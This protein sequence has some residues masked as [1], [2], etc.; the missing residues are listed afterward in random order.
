MWAD[1]VAFVA[2]LVTL[3]IGAEWTVRGAARLARALG[4]S[5]LLVGLTIVALGTSAPELVVGGLASAQD[6]GDLAFGNVLGSN[7]VNIA[8]ILGLAAVF[9]PMRVRSRLVSREIPIMI[10]A[11]AVLAGLV[12]DGSVTRGDGVLLLAAFTLYLAHVIRAARR[13]DRRMEHEWEEYEAEERLVP[14]GRGTPADL[15]LT[16]VGIVGLAVGAELMVDS[17]VSFAS[18]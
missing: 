13:P 9:S 10:V 15:G 4:M 7:I 14:E 16:A 6:V 17:A 2:G 8:L 3:Y 12:L 11:S 1:L 18:A 5:G